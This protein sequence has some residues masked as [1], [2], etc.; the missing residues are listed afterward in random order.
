MAKWVY[1]L[2][3][4]LS[5]GCC[6]LLLRGFLRTRTRLL[7]WTSAAFVG[8]ALN[9]IFLVADFVLFP[10]LNLMVFRQLTALAAMVLFLYGLIE[11]SQ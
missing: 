4:L 8:L 3:A 11:Q 9:N 1:F 10:E 7:L 2:C 6:V 5:I